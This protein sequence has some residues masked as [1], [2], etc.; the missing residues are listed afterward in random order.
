MRSAH[1]DPIRI[2]QGLIRRIVDVEHGGPFSGPEIVR[3]QPEEQLKDVRVK[4]VV[5][6]WAVFAWFVILAVI[7]V[8]VS[9][10]LRTKNSGEEG[11]T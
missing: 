8:S 3:A 4:V 2:G 5:E 7:S 1:H 11:I 6:T 9:S 10:L